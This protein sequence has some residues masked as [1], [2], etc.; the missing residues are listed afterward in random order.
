MNVVEIDRALRRL[1][2]SGMAD[3][4]EV[5]IQGAAAGVPFPLPQNG[6]EAI[7]NHITRYRGEQLRMLT[8]Q[9]AVLSNGSYNLLK[10]D[11]EIYFVYNREGMTPGELDNTLFHY[12]YKIT[13]PAKLAGRR[14]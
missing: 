9:A 14:L 8:N 1:R 3:V 2:L 13:A 4:L 6:L 12:K 11:R 7:W 5:R 10:L